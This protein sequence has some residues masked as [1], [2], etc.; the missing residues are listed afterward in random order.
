ML[1]KGRSVATRS[2]TQGECSNTEPSA[3]TKSC[4]ER[5]LSRSSV[6]MARCGRSLSG[7]EHRF[8]VDTAVAAILEHEVCE[9]MIQMLD[10]QFDGGAFPPFQRRR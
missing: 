3:V 2:G 6:I 4:D 9:H 5:R 1:A 10:H 8:Q 7:T